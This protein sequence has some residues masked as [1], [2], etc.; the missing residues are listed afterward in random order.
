MNYLAHT[1]LSGKNENVIIG[2]FLADIIRRAE[3]SSLNNNYKIG[4]EL[5]RKIDEFT[6]DHPIIKSINKVLRKN[7]RKY[8]P[9][10]TDVLLDYILSQSWHIYSEEAIQNFADVRYDVIIKHLHNFPD[11]VKTIIAKMVDGNFLIKYTTIEGLMFTFEKIQEAARFP[12][13]FSI[14]VEDLEDN[15]EYLYAE[16]N[17]FFPELIKNTEEWRVLKI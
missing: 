12:S 17:A 16:F 14:A 8:A 4:F 1:L 6:D 9:V 11:R 3:I 2:N 10:V 15:Y 7:H 13:D 5:H